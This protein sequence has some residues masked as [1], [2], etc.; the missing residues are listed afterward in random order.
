M[1]THVAPARALP[2]RLLVGV[3]PREAEQAVNDEVRRDDVRRGDRGAADVRVENRA[4]RQRVFAAAAP[5]RPAASSLA[6]QIAEPAV[7]VQ[8]AVGVVGDLRVDLVKVGLVVR[9]R[10]VVVRRC[11]EASATADTP[12]CSSR[13]G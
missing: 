4:E 11:R 8:P 12:G 2:R 3:L 5:Y 6:G 1:P 7:Q 13:P 10:E 9:N